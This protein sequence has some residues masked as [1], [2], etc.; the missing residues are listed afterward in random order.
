MDG[1]VHEKARERLDFMAA[2]SASAACF[3]KGSGVLEGVAI[4]RVTRQS[5]AEPPEREH[6]RSGV[7]N[8]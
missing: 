4:A 1:Y 2:L 8:E 5:R 3:E 6:R 7:T